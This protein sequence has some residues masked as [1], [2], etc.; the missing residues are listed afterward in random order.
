MPTVYLLVPSTRTLPLLVPD[1][2][3]PPSPLPY[4]R[5]T[6]QLDNGIAE[7]RC[8][9]Y[10]AVQLTTVTPSL[11]LRPPSTAQGARSV[12][13]LCEQRQRQREG[14]C[15]VHQYDTLTVVWH[16]LRWSVC[17]GLSAQAEGFRAVAEANAT[18]HTAVRRYTANP[19]A[20]CD[21]C[22]MRRF[23]AA[24]ACAQS[25][26]LTVGGWRPRRPRRRRCRR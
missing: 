22:Q 25:P 1:H 7:R 26:V 15:V 11:S 20:C 19:Q 9:T 24:C 5:T 23:R 8:G 18:V 2:A 13:A 3:R 21:T 6:L 4:P 16:A 12:R 17:G 10:G 14:S